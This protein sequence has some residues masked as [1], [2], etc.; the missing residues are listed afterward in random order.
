MYVSLS[1]NAR[2]ICKV[3]VV[4]SCGSGKT[5][6]CIRKHALNIGMSPFKFILGTIGTGVAKYIK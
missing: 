4:D 2:P 5:I 3:H 6:R 1:K